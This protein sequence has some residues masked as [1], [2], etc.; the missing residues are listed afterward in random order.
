MRSLCH[1]V[2]EVFVQFKHAL[3]TINSYVHT[4]Q[5]R[6]HDN[7]GNPDAK[8]AFKLGFRRRISLNTK[9]P[10]V[11]NAVA[12]DKEDAKDRSYR[13]SGSSLC[14]VTLAVYI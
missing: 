1:L 12:H 2:Q 6:Y 8:Q 13:R 7:H 10:S 9:D 11:K 3:N 14:I 5:N 4:E